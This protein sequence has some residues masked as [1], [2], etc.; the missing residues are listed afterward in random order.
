MQVLYPAYWD[1]TPTQSVRTASVHHPAKEHK[2]KTNTAVFLLAYEL[3]LER[4]IRRQ[5]HRRSPGG[6][7][8]RIKWYLYGRKCQSRSVYRTRGYVPRWTDPS[9]PV[10]A[11]FLRRKCSV[12][13]YQQDEQPDGRQ[14]R[15][16]THF[17]KCR[18]RDLVE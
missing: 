1:Q 13:G 4:S 7:V 6:V 5:V 15:R 2:E 17:A 10:V 9:C 3:I 12:V 16:T 14:K 18:R 11:G 8:N